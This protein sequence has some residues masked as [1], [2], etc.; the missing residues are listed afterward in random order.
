M[1]DH[2][3]EREN[4][5]FDQW[6]LCSEAKMLEMNMNSLLFTVNRSDTYVII[7]SN[8]SQNIFVIC[9]ENE[10]IMMLAWLQTSDQMMSIANVS[11]HWASINRRKTKKKTKQPTTH[12]HGCAKCSFLL[13]IFG[14]S[15]NRTVAMAYARLLVCLFVR[16]FG[17]W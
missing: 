11:K 2:P 17:R 8:A 13:S 5:Y 4:D 3:R 1:V 10:Q 6:L 14:I 7:R 9:Y 15:G 12:S 16:W